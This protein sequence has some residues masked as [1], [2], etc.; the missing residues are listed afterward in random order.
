[1]S[2]SSAK[3]SGPR[4]A[5]RT[6]AQMCLLLLLNFDT[7]LDIFGERQTLTL[8][9]HELLKSLKAQLQRIIA[10]DELLWKTQ[11]RQHWLQEGDCNTKIFHASANGRWRE[12][13][14][15]AVEDA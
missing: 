14:I 12:N 6:K 11:A 3:H 5:C 15:V 13:A 1:M 7:V 10:D 4:A 9:K 8:N 2:T